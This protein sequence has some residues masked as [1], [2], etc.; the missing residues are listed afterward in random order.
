VFGG[1]RVFI[2]PLRRRD[3]AKAA[4]V[5]SAAGSPPI[6]GSLDAHTSTGRRQNTDVTRM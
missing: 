4:R 6:T 3:K 5:H 1:V 2:L